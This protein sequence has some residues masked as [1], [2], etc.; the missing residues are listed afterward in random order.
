MIKR[1]VLYIG[2]PANAKTLRRL[3]YLALAVV[4]VADFL[5]HRA[6]AEYIWDKIP[7][8]G[9]FYGFVSCV[10]IIVVSKFIGHQCGIMQDE[11]Y[12]DD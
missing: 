6:H 2:D 5:V 8:F 12:Y 7:G 3:G 10:L 4:F 11:D 9:A 1:I